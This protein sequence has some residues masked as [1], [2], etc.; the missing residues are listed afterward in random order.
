M[1]IAHH[2]P[3]RLVSSDQ[4]E[5]KDT[6]KID[7]ATTTL[8]TRRHHPGR[9][10]DHGH[11]SEGRDGHR[12][13]GS[14]EEQPRRDDGSHRRLALPNLKPPTKEATPPDRGSHVPV[15]YFSLIHK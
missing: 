13:G 9:R 4:S 6:R 7:H 14:R 3:T 12:T 2:L 15:I 1:E 10:P 8:R 5:L 11:S